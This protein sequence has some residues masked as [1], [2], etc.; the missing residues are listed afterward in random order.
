MLN[1]GYG[2]H[3]LNIMLARMD[4]AQSLSCIINLSLKVWRNVSG[5]ALASKNTEEASTVTGILSFSAVK[6]AQ[7]V[8]TV[9]TQEK[10]VDAEQQE[11]H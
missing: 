6:K 5:V 11:A 2:C 8:D 10:D 7:T 4:F 9:Q 1:N 3:Y